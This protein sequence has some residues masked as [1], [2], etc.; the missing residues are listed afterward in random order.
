MNVGYAP[1]FN[2][3]LVPDPWC[4]EGEPVP[5]ALRPYFRFVRKNVLEYSNDRVPLSLSEYLAFI[6]LL[7]AHGISRRTLSSIVRQGLSERHGHSRWKRAV[8]LDKLQFD[9]FRRYFRSTK[10][11]FSTFFLNST[12]HYQ[13]SYWRN[14]DPRAFAVQPS[15]DEQAEYATAIRF[16]YEEMDHLTGSFLKL[17]GDDTTLVFCTAL[18]QQA[19]VK[20]EATGGAHFYRPRDFHSLA[21]FAGISTRFDVAPI[22]AHQ[23]H[24]D[25][26]DAAAA[27]DAERKLRA[28]QVSSRP[29]LQVERTGARIFAGCQIFTALGRD[30]RL[31]IADTDRSLPFFDVFYILDT[32]KTGMHHPHGMLWIRTPERHHSV[33]EQK[34]PLAAVAPT[35]LNMFRVPCPADMRSQPIRWASSTPAVM[36]KARRPEVP[37][38]QIKR[39]A[40]R[41]QFSL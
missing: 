3:C 41:L 5:K 35:I 9:I 28:L 17:A 13:H 26:H 31:G 19:C 12:A 32:T 36:A 27:A 33:R 1:G 7:M 23:F 15:L 20:H 29:A 18:S 4:T 8:I 30:L 6:R 21:R 37:A 34:V 38:T 40:K 2:G 24:V 10:P 39:S 14:M 22:M 11:G 16:G 25:F